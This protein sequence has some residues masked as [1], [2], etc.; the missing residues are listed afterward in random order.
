MNVKSEQT[1]RTNENTEKTRNE[2]QIRESA[3]NRVRPACGLVLIYIWLDEYFA[4]L[5]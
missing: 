4:R 5:Y 2:G 1:Q 3:G